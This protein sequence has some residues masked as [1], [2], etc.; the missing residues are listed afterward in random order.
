MSP[1]RRAETYLAVRLLD[2]ERRLPAGG[3]T[4]A[5]QPDDAAL[6]RDYVD[7]VAV[8]AQVRAQLYY[9]GRAP[10]PATPVRG[11]LGRAV[12]R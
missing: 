6:W 10:A 11:P 12:V 3:C 8:F 7:T 2:L 5:G 4:P 9:A 1:L